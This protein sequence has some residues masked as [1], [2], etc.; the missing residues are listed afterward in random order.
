[1][2]YF[3]KPPILL[4]LILKLAIIDQNLISILNLRQKR[5]LKVSKNLTGQKSENDFVGLSK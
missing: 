1:M 4:H 3:L 5:F 2:N